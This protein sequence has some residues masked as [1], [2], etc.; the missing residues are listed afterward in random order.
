HNAVRHIPCTGIDLY[1]VAA[2]EIGH[3]L[4]L[5]HSR[6]LKAL[7]APLY[8]P[9]TGEDIHLHS[10]DI[11]AVYQ[12]NIC[13]DPS[14]DAITVIGNGS[15][16]AFKMSYDIGYPRKIAADWNGLPDN[17]DAATTDQEGNTYFFK[18]DLYWLYDENGHGI[19]GYPRKISEGL[20]DMPNNIDAAMT[21]SYDKKPYFFKGNLFWQYSS[22]G[23]QGSWPMF[24]HSISNNLPQRIDAAFMWTNGKNYLFADQYYYKLS[25]WRVMKVGKVT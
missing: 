15:T 2:H 6:N 23:L 10:D 19:K 1:S 20:A 11:K 24:L 4:G 25:S 9:Y 14:I 18:G 5:K 21:W 16:F 3:S 22:W 7:M 12:Y 8:Q 17:L 13:D